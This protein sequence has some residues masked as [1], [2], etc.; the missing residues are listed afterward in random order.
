MSK[1]TMK[2]FYHNLAECPKRKPLNLT[3]SQGELP[4][5]VNI[6]MMIFIAL[7]W[8]KQHN[9]AGWFCLEI[10]SKE[11]AEGRVGEAYG[12]PIMLGKL[13]SEE[14]ELW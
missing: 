3:E 2:A 7:V 10:G 8:E 6:S 4:P 9:K 1:D 5:Y 12:L 14:G 13:A 11:N